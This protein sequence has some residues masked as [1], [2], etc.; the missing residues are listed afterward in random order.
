M[1]NHNGFDFFLISNR[2]LVVING[3][4]VRT[5][6]CC[7]LLLG[8]RTWRAVLG[9]DPYYTNTVFVIHYEPLTPPE[10]HGM[11]WLDGAWIEGQIRIRPD[12]R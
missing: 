11:L 3:V 12:Q 6:L 4:R 10:A 9:A 5:W 8:M 7:T 1:M 2:E